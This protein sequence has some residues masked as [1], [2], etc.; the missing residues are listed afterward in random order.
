VDELLDEHRHGVS[1]AR[2]RE[3][4]DEVQQIIYDEYAMFP[5]FS[6]ATIFGV[7]TSVHNVHP[8]SF[9][10]HA[11]LFWDVYDWWID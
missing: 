10:V 2:A 11:G 1:E 3:I 6:A 7:R 9:G 5:L 4:L 8:T